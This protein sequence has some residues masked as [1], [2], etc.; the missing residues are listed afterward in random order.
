[1]F[2]LKNLS[3]ELLIT[4]LENVGNGPKSQILTLEVKI[5]PKI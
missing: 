4:E 5:H 3:H 2:K 1:M